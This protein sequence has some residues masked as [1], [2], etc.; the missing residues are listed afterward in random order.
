MGDFEPIE[1]H[2][3]LSAV[4]LAFDPSSAWMSP[5]TPHLPTAVRWT[6]MESP[7]RVVGVLSSHRRAADRSVRRTAM[8]LPLQPIEEQL[9]TK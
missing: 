8:C 1:S 6:S 3:R 7:V 2:A 4:G 5:T 9:E